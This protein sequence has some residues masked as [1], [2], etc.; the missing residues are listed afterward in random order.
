MPIT[1][2]HLTMMM[3]MTILTMSANLPMDVSSFAWLPTMSHQSRK[4]NDMIK[5]RRDDEQQELHA[6]RLLRS[7]PFQLSMVRVSGP[8]S[9]W[10]ATNDESLALAAVDETASSS[11]WLSSEEEKNGYKNSN[12]SNNKISSTQNDTDALLHDR[13]REIVHHRPEHLRLT[14]TSQLQSESSSSSSTTPRN[15]SATTSVEADGTLGDIMSSGLITVPRAPL[16]ETYGFCNPLDR[17]VLT[18][19]GNL[20]RLIS[21]Y[22]DSAVSVY[23]DSCEPRSNY[24]VLTTGATMMDNS[25]SQQERAQPPPLRVWDRTVH[26]TV[27]NQR[28][29]TATS[30]IQVR[31]ALCVTLVESGKVGLGQLFRYLDLLPEFCLVDAGRLE[32]GGGFWREYTLECAEVSCLIHEEFID[33][34]WELEDDDGQ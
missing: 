7:L 10:N 28:F 31:D 4:R 8:S 24:D 13:I 12:K 15:D 11:S 6:I 26:L 14:Q 34:L 18:A 30:V 27:R 3:M 5:C 20:Q 1:M 22:Y 23:V 29:C 19:N 9:P 2:P 16:A 21:S 17:M 25:N 33:G 32:N